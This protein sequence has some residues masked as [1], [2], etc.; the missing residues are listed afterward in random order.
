MAKMRKSSL[1]RDLILVG[2]GLATGVV[3][4]IGTAIGATALFAAS[5]KGENI[6]N[7]TK[8]NL[9]SEDYQNKSVLQLVMAFVNHEV[10]YNTLEGLEK[11]TP[12]VG[13]LYAKLEEIA[14]NYGITLNKEEIF[15]LPY[16]DMPAYFEETLTH[17][18]SLAGF[19]GV[20]ENS[21]EIL[22]YFFYARDD[23]GNYDFSNPYTVAD[24][25]QDGFIDGLINSLTIGIVYGG[26]TEG[27]MN[28]L[29]NFTLADFND[30]DKIDSLIIGSLSGDICTEVETDYEH[31][32]IYY[33][34][35]TSVADST[36]VTYTVHF[37]SG[38]E[39]TYTR[40]NVEGV[41]PYEV[42]LAENNKFYLYVNEG[43]DILKPLSK[44]KI[45]T[46]KNDPNKL[47]NEMTL[48]TFLG[49]VDPS[50]KIMYAIKDLTLAEVSSPGTIKDKIFDLT[51]EDVLGEVDENNKILVAIKDLKLSELSEGDTIKNTIYDMKLADLVGD[52][53]DNAIIQALIAKDCS[54]NDLLRDE[55]LSDLTLEEVVGSEACDSNSILN[56]LRG[57]TMSQ[58]KA[59]ENNPFNTLTI[60]NLV[61]QDEIDSSTVLQ[62]I[63]D[64]TIADLK[65]QNTLEGL[66]L[67][68]LLGEEACSEENSKILYALK[69]YSIADLKT[70]GQIESLKLSNFI[71][72]GAD[73]GLLLA[74]QDLSLSQ[75][76][77][78][79]AINDAIKDLTVGEVFG[80]I[81]P[82]SFFGIISGY[83]IDELKDGN[84]IENELYIKQ[85]LGDKSTG[86]ETTNTYVRTDKEQNES[87]TGDIY[88]V[89][90]K[91]ALD[92]ELTYSYELLYEAG[93][94]TTTEKAIYEGSDGKYWIR[95]SE[96]SNLNSIIGEWT[97]AD[98][99]DPDKFD[100]I[101]VKDLIS[102]EGD[103]NPIID[104]LG[105][106]TLGELNESS[107]R[108]AMGTVAI[109][110][111]LET[112]DEG[113]LTTD[114]P[115]ILALVKDE[116]GNDVKVSDLE[117]RIN[118]LTL[119][120][121]FP[122]REGIIKYLDGSTKISELDSAIN[123]AR[124]VD[125]FQDQIFEKN[126]SDE[127]A[128]KTEWK[129]LLTPTEDEE[130]NPVHLSSVGVSYASDPNKAYYDS[131]KLKDGFVDMIENFKYH[132][133]HEQLNFLKEAG[134]L[135][136]DADTFLLNEIGN[137]GYAS[138][139]DEYKT[140]KSASTTF[141]ELTLN[142]LMAIMS[143]V[144]TQPFWN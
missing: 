133:Q 18:I 90:F 123:D 57:Y 1:L 12:Q 7:A 37:S 142:E 83:T 31:P 24:F 114:N 4:T 66:K 50:D 122:D 106:L 109:R 125:L 140:G 97:I 53:A 138:L 46:L 94:S 14:A 33:V 3:G 89:V 74:L 27:I 26:E 121:V 104:S 69:D 81:D 132:T 25:T 117:D 134:M 19:L 143:G 5:I 95:F 127:D 136:S 21:E 20:D 113:H 82:D 54:V 62:A 40:P 45:S 112:D 10:D 93:E 99:K 43:N 39:Y 88:T 102:T 30:P 9:F 63:K 76:S 38:A 61:G 29:K 64:F 70:P 13:E 85:I 52:D 103:D 58:L 110:A 23:M 124:I 16:A 119:D 141:G 49:E 28:A 98:L 17:S 144:V 51:I 128:V 96:E 139:P 73:N 91:D 42:Y 2:A 48:E 108:H 92:N 116:Y 71:P 41:K 100:S 107:V 137:I 126:A 47:L 6:E 129:F 115:I 56:A 87:H 60:T 130:H 44:F 77:D 131:Y 36:L 15:R 55:T 65:D 11:F 35:T 120:D 80:D 68:E 72:E 22:K 101:K 79:T 135:S 84:T 75:L 59:T 111:F 105:E 86:I 8:L 34:E 78:N 67:G 32:T 118:N